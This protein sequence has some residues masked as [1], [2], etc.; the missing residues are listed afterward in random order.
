[1]YAQWHDQW[2]VSNWLSY[3]YDLL[4]SVVVFMTGIFALWTGVSDGFAA[5]IF[6]Q[7]QTF[8]A[9]VSALT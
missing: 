9:C 8:G 6:V 5:I 3:R 7:A 1:L 2:L 4:G